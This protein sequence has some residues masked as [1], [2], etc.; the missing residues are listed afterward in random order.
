MSALR[1]RAFIGLMRLSE[2]ANS[3]SLKMPSRLPD[4][5]RN[6]GD[7]PSALPAQFLQGFKGTVVDDPGSR[8]AGA[9]VQA[10]GSAVM[11]M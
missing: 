1:P 5:D 11:F 3:L 7:Y 8:L 9:L 2:R 10:S 4:S 6:S